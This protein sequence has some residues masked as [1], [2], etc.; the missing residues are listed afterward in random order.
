MKPL[1]KYMANLAAVIHIHKGVQNQINRN[2]TD[3]ET[4]IIFA[5]HYIIQF[6]I[7]N[8]DH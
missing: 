5:F 7:E 3:Y 8:N 4:L 2:E 6:Q 1:K